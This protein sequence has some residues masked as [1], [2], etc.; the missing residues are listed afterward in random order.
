MDWSRDGS[1]RAILRGFPVAVLE[2]L[3]ADAGHEV[4]V[5]PVAPARCAGMLRVRWSSPAPPRHGGGR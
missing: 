2:A 5:V 1:D 3:A 4:Q